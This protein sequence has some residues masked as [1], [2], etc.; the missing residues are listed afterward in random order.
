[1]TFRIKLG[2]VALTSVLA[3]G[4]VAVQAK[5]ETTLIIVSWGGA[6]SASQIKAYHEPY[7]AAN[8][9]IKILND[10]S[11]NQGLAKLRA[12][13]E[14]GNVT[15]DLVDM[16]GP[17]AII[18][19]DDGLVLEIDPDVDL[20]PADDGTPASEDFLAGSLIPGGSNCFSPQIVYSTT[21]G[22]RTD[23]VGN[24]VPTSINDVFDLEKFP[25]KRSLQKKPIG[26]LEWALIADGVDPAEIYTVLD[27]PEGVSRTV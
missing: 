1:M 11:A 20:A 7:M 27:T 19:C 10:D 4:L 2:A 25:G 16:E 6:Y 24:E 5:A 26:N 15:W 12:Q 17:D 9:E 13:A 14:A 23:M 22:Y 21:F 8:P 18:A 3:L